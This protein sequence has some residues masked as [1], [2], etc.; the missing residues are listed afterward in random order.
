MPYFL[1]KKGKKPHDT[2]DCTS[3]LNPRSH[4]KH[5]NDKHKTALQ[6]EICFAESGYT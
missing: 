3:E 5:E 2:Y 6:H 4:V 1:L